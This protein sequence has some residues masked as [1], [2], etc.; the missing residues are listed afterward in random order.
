MCTI[1]IKSNK[2]SF[3]GYKIIYPLNDKLYSPVTG[4][5]YKPG[6]VKSVSIRTANEDRTT[7]NWADLGMILGPYGFFY[8]SKMKG[9]TGVFVNLIDAENNIDGHDGEVIFKM[10]I[11]GDLYHGHMDTYPIITGTHIDKIEEL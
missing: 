1:T 5:E 3:T 7:H 11:S 9:R 6:K 2:K 4:I 10:T 8:N